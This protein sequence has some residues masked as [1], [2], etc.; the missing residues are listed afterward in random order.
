MFNY[1]QAWIIADALHCSMDALGGRKP[2]QGSTSALTA[3]ERS[4]VDNYRNME[5]TERGK[6]M[7]VSESF[8]VAAE[9]NKAREVGDVERAGTALKDGGKSHPRVRQD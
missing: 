3:D 7:G 8:V 5:A 1:E 2:P 6:L 4:L 9:K